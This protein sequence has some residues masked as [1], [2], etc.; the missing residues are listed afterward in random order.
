M[1]KIG[2]RSRVTVTINMITWVCML[3][4]EFAGGKQIIWGSRLEKLQN[5]IRRE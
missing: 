5:N 2:T 3:W 1:Q 4:D